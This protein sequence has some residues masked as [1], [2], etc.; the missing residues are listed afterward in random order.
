MIP[1]SSPSPFR[2]PLSSHLHVDN[3]T[4]PWC[5]QE[6]PPAKLK[7]ISGKIAAKEREQTEAL[8]AK[9]EQQYASEKAQAE[10]KAVADLEA[11]RLASATREAAAREEARKAAEIAANEKLAAAELKRQ[12]LQEQINQ[13]DAAKKAAEEATTTLQ[14]QLE[15]Q[16]LDNETALATAKTEAQAREA[17]IRTEAQKAAQDAAA[18]QLAESMAAWTISEADLKEQISQA[19][20]TRLA[21]EQTGTAL[22]QQIEELRTA[23]AA[24]VAKLKEDAVADAARIR[25]EAA[26]AAEA[27]VRE[28][29][30]TNEKAVAEANAKVLE[31]EDK[32]ATLNEQHEAA[33]NTRLNEQ[34]EILEQDKDKALNA[35]RAKAFEENQKLTTKV[36]ELQ[37]ALDKKTNEELGEGAEVDLF[38][39]LKKEFPDDKIDRVAKGTAGADILHVVRHNGRDCG[40][41]IYDS[42]NHKVFRNDHVTKLRDDQI[43][44]KAEH[45]ILSTHKFPAGTSQLHHQDGVLLANP[46]RVVSVVTMIRQH[47]VQTL[48]LRLSGAERESKTA[49]LYAFITSDHCGQLL[50]R[51]DSHS[52]ELLE[53]QVKERKWHDAHWKK[54]R[55]R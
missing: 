2:R 49:A 50:D 7:E 17:Q 15:Q 20:Q 23:S 14:Q 36:G 54:E 10:A 45:A 38:E 1:Q 11:E 42:K 13:S 34:R 51:V 25:Q 24:E 53:Q 48:T 27:L 41:V 19:E 8:T 39:A 16:R 32:L 31:A 26:D 40:T 37:R 30:E 6:I 47:L 5:E 52:E 3:E 55:A 33:I 9:L 46:A 35:E 22:K 29:L 28:K 44:A 18:Q 21:A 12:E 4:C 43:A